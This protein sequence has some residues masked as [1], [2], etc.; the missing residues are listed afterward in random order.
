MFNGSATPNETKGKKK[1][2]EQA[3]QIPAAE[4]WAMAAAAD[5]TTTTRMTVNSLFDSSDTVSNASYSSAHSDVHRNHGRTT[6]STVP[7]PYD[8]FS[9]CRST[10]NTRGDPD[11]QSRPKLSLKHVSSSGNWSAAAIYVS[12]IIHL[13]ATRV[14]PMWCLQ[15]LVSSRSVSS[16][17]AAQIFAPTSFDTC[18]R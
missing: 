7:W 4:R 6:G 16:N 15:S 14:D 10:S 11:Q 8:S 5:P 1:T 13:A 9:C 2:Y 18:M 17:L 12:R 3:A